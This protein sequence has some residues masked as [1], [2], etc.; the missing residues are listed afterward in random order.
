MQSLGAQPHPR[1]RAESAV[2]G[3]VGAF[4]VCGQRR[5]G[6]F[7]HRVVEAAVDRG[8]LVRVG[9]CECPREEAPAELGMAELVVGDA[10]QG[11]EYLRIG[12]EVARV[13]SFD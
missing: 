10:L 11:R 3:R 9:L 6:G 12:G 8:A 4:C 7:V 5:A 2:G 13:C 1:A